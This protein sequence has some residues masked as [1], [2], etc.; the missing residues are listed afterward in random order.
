[1][2]SADDLL[3][4]WALDKFKEK[5]RKYAYDRNNH[6]YNHLVDCATTTA[7]AITVGW[8][9]RCYSEYTRDD[10]FETSFMISCD[11][12]VTHPFDWEVNEWDLP[13]V[14]REMAEYEELDCIY[15]EE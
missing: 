1:M 4:V 9:C 8:E 7:T 10:G 12:G 11:C 3:V 14:L 6:P 15:D 13:T 2:N 5:F